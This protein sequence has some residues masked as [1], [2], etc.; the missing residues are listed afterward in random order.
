MYIFTPS[1]TI[2]VS[3]SSRTGSGPI[4][5]VY[6]GSVTG[7]EIG[8]GADDGTDDVT[9]GAIDDPALLHAQQQVYLPQTSSLHPPAALTVHLVQRI[10]AA[11]YI[12]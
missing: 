9:A 2:H 3:L 6:W 11:S 4:L 8:D 7:G 10:P 5:N 12:P 1:S